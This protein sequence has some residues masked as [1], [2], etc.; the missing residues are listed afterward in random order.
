MWREYTI[1]LWLGKYFS[2]LITYFEWNLHHLLRSSAQMR[3]NS[4]G[5]MIYMPISLFLSAG[6]YVYKEKCQSLYPQW[7][8]VVMW[9]IGNK[10]LQYYKDASKKACETSCWEQRKEHFPGYTL[11]WSM[12]GLRE[13]GLIIYFIFFPYTYMAPRKKNRLLS[14]K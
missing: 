5:T 8:Q 11:D 13:K 6:Y 1:S 3:S 9:R 2:H 7:T 10:L 4:I 12:E 14:N